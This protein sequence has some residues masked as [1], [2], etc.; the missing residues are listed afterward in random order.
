MEDGAPLR[1][2][3]AVQ[4]HEVDDPAEGQRDIRHISYISGRFNLSQ[5]PV[6]MMTLGAGLRGTARGV[7][8][9][10]AD[11]HRGSPG[12]TTIIRSE[13][14][15][16]P[17]RSSGARAPGIATATRPGIVRVPDGHRARRRPE[18]PT[19]I[20]C[21][22]AGGGG[23]HRMRRR[24]APGEAA[25]CERAGRRSTTRPMRA[26]SGARPGSRKARRG[27]GEALPGRSQPQCRPVWYSDTR[28][29]LSRNLF[30]LLLIPPVTP[31]PIPVPTPVPIPAPEERISP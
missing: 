3:T 15:R 14:T 7:A 1:T 29:L 17:R 2:E 23:G 25:A 19:A 9:T 30:T 11:G 12:I 4:A 22:S 24:R 16:G 6:R 18:G 21:G 31:L 13:S 26:L 27:A 20:G 8:T 10:A 28:A 5:A